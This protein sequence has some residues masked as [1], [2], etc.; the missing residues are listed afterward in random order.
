MRRCRHAPLPH[1]V[2][3]AT[4][5]FLHPLGFEH[6]RACDHIVEKLS[7]V[8]DHEQRAGILHE[9]LLEQFDGL[10]IEIVGGLVE[11]DHVGWLGKQ[12]G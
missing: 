7:V 8:A 3:V 10:G 2:G 9:P 6:K 4:D 5:V 1:P 11:H 12:L